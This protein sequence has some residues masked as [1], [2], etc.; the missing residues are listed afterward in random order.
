MRAAH[1]ALAVVCVVLS[2]L[3][4]S[5]SFFLPEPNAQVEHSIK[6]EMVAPSKHA[7]VVGASSGIG[8]AVAKELA[9]IVAKLTLCS[10]SYPEELLKTIQADNP[11]LEV[12]H[13][14]LDVSLMHEV[15]KFTTKHA[16]TQ[17][18]WIV[19]SPGI[20]TLN[21]RTETSEGL[22]VKMA[23]HYYGRFMLIHDL[24][25]G[26]DHPGV[27]V[28]NILAA[29]HGGAMDMNDLDLKHTYPGKR[30][31]DATT[32]YSDLMAQAFSE[33]APNASF[34]H[35]M[36]GFV[37]TDL[38]KGLPWFLR[39]PMKGLATVFGRSPAA[40]GKIM[41][42]A[43]LNDDYAT[44]WRLLDYNGKEASTTKYHTE[45]AKDAVWKHTVKTIDDIMK[46]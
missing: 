23:T 45:E 34:M 41:V 14:K 3:F 20:M 11:N 39:V 25:K 37:N 33:H 6:Q 35:V 21:G 5:Y 8:L 15:R 16:D 38:S 10:R 13:E 44:G 26:L 42:S 30:C 32:Q 2:V 1:L 29:G 19:M 22:D 4:S 9:P 12:V 40:C 31:A 7:L 27:R 24:L 46:E 28:L 43:L 17:F 18:D 36:P